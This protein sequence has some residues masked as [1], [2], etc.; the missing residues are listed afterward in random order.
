M[1]KTEEIPDHD[2]IETPEENNKNIV[3]VDSLN[4][5][6]DYL[7]EKFNI[8]RGEIRSLQSTK[9]RAAELGIEFEGI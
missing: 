4:D 9:D 8:K 3:K 7:V 1:L 2:A 5:A 6:K